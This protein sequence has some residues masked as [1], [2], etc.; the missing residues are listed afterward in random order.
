MPSST[1][2]KHTPQN[3]S[4]SLLRRV[5]IKLGT[6]TVIDSQNEFNAARLEPL[7]SSI[8]TF[9]HQQQR[10][11]VLVSS[12]AVG[13]GAARL[14]IS[15]ARLH[16]VVMRQACAAVGQSLLMQSYGQ[17]FRAHKIKTAQL[18]VTE[19]DFAGLQRHANLRHTI[20][21]LLKLN[22]LPII[23]E[24]DAT[25]TA[26]IEYLDKSHRVF[27]DNDLLAGLVTSK[28]EADALILLTNVD[29]LLFRTE[30]GEELISTVMSITPELRQLARGPS[31]NGRGG[32]LTK[33]KAAEI[34]MRTGA[35]AIIAN[36]TRPDTLS[37]IFAGESVGTRFIPGACLNGKRRWITYIAGVQG[38]LVVDDGARDAILARKAS[39]L[40][41]GV[42]R[43]EKPFNTRDVVSIVDSTG[44]EFAI[45]ITNC[46]SREAHSLMKKRAS[47]SGKQSYSKKGKVLVTRN[48]IVIL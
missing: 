44:R 29:G 39:L 10:Q 15:K 8:A 31:P 41:S 28:L 40:I 4:A 36:G 23:N 43:L 38:R 3:L 27:S 11:I 22:V 46:S 47:K 45:G 12:G 19:P 34:A 37:R 30:N 26:E 17:L 1:H 33:L 20:E 16:D 5:V 18:L 6:N 25:S 48:N 9:K 35:L 32:M 2:S 24:N 42:T 14:G 21:K 13:M 7:V